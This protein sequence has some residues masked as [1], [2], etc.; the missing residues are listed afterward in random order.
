MFEISVTDMM[1]P[2]SGYDVRKNGV[3][4]AHFS[5]AWEAEKWCK[6]NN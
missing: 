3:L 2:N 5:N 6:Y 4:V 1:N